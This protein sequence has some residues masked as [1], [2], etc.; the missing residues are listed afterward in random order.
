MNF[1]I[2]ICSAPCT[3]EISQEDYQRDLS[4]AIDTLTGKGTRVVQELEK[5]ML[6]HSNTEEYEMAARV[7]DQIQGLQ[8]TLDAG[9]QKISP[10]S[11][12]KIG[13]L[14]KD[15]LGYFEKEGTACV[16]VLFARAG[17]LIDTQS[18]YFNDVDGQDSDKVLT[19][20]I[21]QFYLSRDWMEGREDIDSS[22]YLPGTDL[23]KM[24]NEIMVPQKLIDTEVLQESFERMKYHCTI[25]APQRGKKNELVKLA[26]KN[27]KEHFM[28]Y[29]AELKDIYRV[30]AELKQKL[31]LQNYPRRIECFDISNLGDTG[32]V[33]SRVTFVEGKPEKSLYRHYKLR[34]VRTQND[35]AAMR[36]VLERRLVKSSEYSKGKQ[37]EEPPELLVVDGGKGQL[38]MAMEN[39]T[40]A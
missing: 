24:P 13:D 1:Q 9:E 29:N 2:G 31:R 36:E 33:A 11:K 18:F 8:A 7:R 39:R 23:K 25:R 26:Q 20:F 15:I 21:A 32:I 34:G 30:L 5:I 6:I 38:S 22:V 27:A 37:F 14:D 40:G 16:V 12:N 4:Q 35:F 17:K 19:D 10:N 3:G 28:Q